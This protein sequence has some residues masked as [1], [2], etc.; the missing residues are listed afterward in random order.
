MDKEKGYEIPSKPCFFGVIDT[1]DSS[2]IKL[3]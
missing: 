3:N 2:C 1:E